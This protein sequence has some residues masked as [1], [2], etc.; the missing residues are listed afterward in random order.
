MPYY[1]RRRYP[2]RNYQRKA[3]AQKSWLS[4]AASMAS[5]ALSVANSV[6]KLINVEYKAFDDGENYAT[7]TTTATVTALS[8]IPQGDTSITRDGY[9]VKV[10]KLSLR[11]AAYCDPDAGGAS[12]GPTLFRFM[13][14]QALSDVAPTANLILNGGTDVLS[15]RNIDGTAQFRV[16]HDKIMYLSESD[17][18]QKFVELNF[19][20]ENLPCEHITWDQTD[21]AGT[22]FRKGGLYV[23]TISDTVANPPIFQWRSRIR[24]TDN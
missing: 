13:L 22:N 18:E 2:K 21:T 8:Q 4:S 12:Q 16:L 14:I 1:K 11:Y 17:S 24:F 10:L 3:P 9:S 19:K 5:K 7:Q 23:L 15:Y 6:R 20:G